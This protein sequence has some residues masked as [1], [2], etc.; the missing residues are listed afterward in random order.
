MPG[1]DSFFLNQK[2]R[3]IDIHGEA[4]VGEVPLRP[5]VNKT[6]MIM[7]AW[8]YHDDGTNRSGN[9]RYQNAGTVA[10]GKTG[11]VLTAVEHLNLVKGAYNGSSV[12]GIIL[13]DYDSY[14]EAVVLSL[15]AGKKVRVQALVL[16]WGPD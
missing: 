9:W 1:F 6:W 4:A 12:M 15:G 3:V 11:V 13:A 8:F 7:D 2:I 14:P 5:P 10:P 16:E